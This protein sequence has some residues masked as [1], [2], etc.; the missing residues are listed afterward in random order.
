MGCLF[1]YAYEYFGDFRAAVALH[2]VVNF[3]SYLLGNTAL[4][5]SAFVSWPV[6]VL[7]LALC[8][9]CLFLLNR[10]KKIF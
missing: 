5:V 7:F 10:Q 1:I 3:F 9:V 2:A 6:C 4:G 8:A